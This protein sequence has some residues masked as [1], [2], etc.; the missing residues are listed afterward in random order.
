VV[1]S[2]DGGRR[3]LSDPQRKDLRILSAG[4]CDLAN[5][6]SIQVRGEFPYLIPL[7]WAPNGDRILVSES[8]NRM[9]TALVLIDAAGKEQ[10]TLATDGRGWPFWWSQDGSALWYARS[11]PWGSNPDYVRGPLQPVELHLSPSGAPEGPA[12]PV[13]W[14]RNHPVDWFSV[15]ADGSRAVVAREV[16][17]YRVL[18]VAP[19]DDAAVVEPLTDMI[20]GETWA[21]FVWAGTWSAVEGVDLSADG[22]WLLLPQEV[23]GGS[24][25]FK[26]PVGGG[27]PVRLTRSGQVYGGIWSPDGRYAAYLAPGRDSVRLQFVGTDGRS[28]G[29]IAGADLA[30][31][32]RPSWGAS[33]LV[34]Q[35]PDFQVESVED[36]VIEYG[37]RTLSGEWKPIAAGTGGTPT[38]EFV[39]RGGIGPLVSGARRTD[40]AGGLWREGADSTTISGIMVLPT[41]S[42][43]G[44]KVVFGWRRDSGP[45]PRG[46]W[47]WIAEGREPVLAP[48]TPAGDD[49]PVGWT[50]DGKGL[51]WLVG[52]DLYLWP[53]G[54][55]RRK[56]LTLPEGRVSCKP[57][58][59]ADTPEFL[60][61]EDL[62]S[63]E[64]FLI[65]N[66]NRGGA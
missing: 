60:C 2:P 26:L 39:V 22:R 9:S 25:L 51:Y 41:V 63:V 1:I 53:L 52:R 59:D 61:V 17:R 10:R 64:L 34:Y 47:W 55:E 6:D 42:P 57:W 15:S 35:R 54:G 45:E 21:P 8:D 66:F 23:P 4:S 24:D 29:A 20:A 44:S 11:G 40:W 13:P 33:R 36:P 38:G 7:A 48:L 58:P 3:V 46:S 37:R 49:W 43:D 28:Y 19:G 16:N 5:A 18:R 32:A 30:Y 56:L 62:S 50:R 27:D 65:E 12:T 31:F 14:F